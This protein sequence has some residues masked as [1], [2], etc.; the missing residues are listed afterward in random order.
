[1]IFHCL[2]RGNDR[3][4]LFADDADYAAFE[5]V[6]ESALQAVPV[7]L[8]AYCLMPN[9]APLSLSKG[10]ICCCGP[11]R[12]ASWRRQQRLTTTHVRRWHTHRHTEGRGHL[13][14]SLP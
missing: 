14:Q 8:L 7:R 10:G 5:R 11:G 6:L 1:V 3:R 2:N 13:Y 9:H 12:T 4:E